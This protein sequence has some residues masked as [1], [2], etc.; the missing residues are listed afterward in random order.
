M[1]VRTP[2]IVCLETCKGLTELSIPFSI[3]LSWME[4]SYPQVVNKQLDVTMG[5]I[6][7]V[8]MG[9]SVAVGIPSSNANL[10]RCIQPLGSA[11]TLD[12]DPAA[13]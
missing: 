13:K 9:T 8:F 7:C 2:L 4:N 5:F 11:K 10:T 6:D 3:A 1:E 12:S